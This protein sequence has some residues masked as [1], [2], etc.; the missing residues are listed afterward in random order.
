MITHTLVKST[1]SK[2]G[3]LEVWETHNSEAGE[4]EFALFVGDENGPRK[5]GTEVEVMRLNSY[6]ATR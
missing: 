3:T 2:S 1:N 6:L 5:V 4:S